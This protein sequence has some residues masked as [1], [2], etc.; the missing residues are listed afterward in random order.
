MRKY[1]MD[2]MR[3]VTILLVVI[4]HVFYYYNNI[5]IV[6]MFPGAEVYEGQMSFAGVFQ[7]FVYPWF[8]LLLFVVSGMGA[9]YSLKKT[10]HK[11]FLKKRAQR[12]LAPSTLG[13]LVFGWI[14]GYV[15]YIQ[16]A[17]PN[18]PDAVPG[19]VRWIIIF[20]CGIGALWFCHVV[21]FNDLILVLIRKITG[22]LHRDEEAFRNKLVGEW[23]VIPMY[24]LLWGGAQI[25]NMP[26]ITAYRLGI[27][28]VGFLA[29]YYLFTSDKFVEA[30]KKHVWIYGA[31]AIV[32]FGLVIHF[33]YG[34]VYSDIGFLST[35]YTTAYAWLMVLFVVGLFAR[36]FDHEYQCTAYFNRLSFGIYV[37]HIPVLLVA[38]YFLCRSGLALWGIYIVE[39]VVAMVV[40]WGL[41][42]LVSRIPVLRFCILGIHR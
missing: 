30:L 17:A 7:Y 41:Y 11:T 15:V 36:F 22:V 2:N 40:S 32:S 20:C 42:E 10:D 38:N 14:G 8:M 9:Y 6:A 23:M 12:I 37:F 4:F 35:W 27:Y 34:T 33:G 21:F 13:V 5:G 31:L 28:L 19:F 39:F 26:I 25:L 16:T 3:W 1:Y 18:M 24:F 29:G